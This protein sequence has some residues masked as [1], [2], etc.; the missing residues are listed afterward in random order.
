MKSEGRSRLVPIVKRVAVA[1]A[2]KKGI[3]KFQEVRRPQKP[4]FPGRVAKLGLLAVGGGG[5][6]Y[7]FVSGKLQPMVDKVM[8]ASGSSSDGDRWS[9]PTTTSSSRV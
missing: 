6:F 3:D 1:V 9:S 2:I 8:G 4:S 7:A 5:L